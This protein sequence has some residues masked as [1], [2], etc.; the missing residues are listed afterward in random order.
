MGPVSQHSVS[1]ARR[2][3]WMILGLLA[4]PVLSVTSVALVADVASTTNPVAPAVG[5][6]ATLAGL[7]AGAA[8]FRLAR[9]VH[10]GTVAVRAMF[11]ALRG[12]VDRQVLAV[13][14]VL[15]PG[16]TIRPARVLVPSR[17]GRRG[18]PGFER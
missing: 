18:P 11:A 7:M 8:V 17:V 13:A 9:A 12:A 16:A 2:A 10:S 3:G 15:V 5:V 14:T 4:I 1:E 6:P